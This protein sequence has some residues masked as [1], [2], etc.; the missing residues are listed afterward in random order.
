MM[1]KIV[2][3]QIFRLCNDQVCLIKLITPS[4]EATNNWILI[5]L[6]NMK[7]FVTNKVL[8]I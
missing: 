6:Q 1:E 5:Q 2:V 7:I 8:H 4:E 3:T